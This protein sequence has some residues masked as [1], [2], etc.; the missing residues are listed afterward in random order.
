MEYDRKLL[1]EWSKM[2]DWGTHL[3][4]NGGLNKYSSDEGFQFLQNE[5]YSEVKRRIACCK[6]ILKKHKDVFLYYVIA[7][8]YDRCNEDEHFVYLFKCPVEANC[9][10]AL[11]IDP[12]YAPAK[13]LLQK[14]QEWI[15]FLDEGKEDNMPDPGVGFGG[16]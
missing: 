7:E 6:E 10:R 14:T 11:D 5:Y 16:K 9:L 8:L 3:I 15:E 12:N 13:K 1:G 4:Q 2:P